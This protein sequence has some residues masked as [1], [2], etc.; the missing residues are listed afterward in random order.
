MSQAD[1]P[2]MT[3]LA[4]VLRDQRDL[5]QARHRYEQVL[6]VAPHDAHALSG[7]AGVL[8]D[9]GDEHGAQQRFQQ[10]GKPHL[11]HRSPRSTRLR[12]R[13]RAAASS[14]ICQSPPPR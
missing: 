2:A 6:A 12:W 9:L 4:A 11:V 10:R 5:S 8:H 13:R 1:L 7:L 3:G 14:P